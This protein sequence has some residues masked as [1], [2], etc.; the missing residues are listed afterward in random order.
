MKKQVLSFI[1]LV[2]VLVCNTNITT[3]AADLDTFEFRVLAEENAQEQFDIL[4]NS[5]VN[6]TFIIQ[7][8]CRFKQKISQLPYLRVK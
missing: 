3:E 8:Q 1:T 7:I 2:G 4:M 6:D 5:F